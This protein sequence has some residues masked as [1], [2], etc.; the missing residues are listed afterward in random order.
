MASRGGPSA[1]RELDDPRVAKALA[2]PLRVR[3]LGVLERRSA[4]PR[5]LAEALDVGL[6]NLAYHVRKLRDYG[7]IELERRQKVGGAYEHVYRAKERP[8]ITASAWDALPDIAK[9][10]VIAATLDRLL[11]LIADAAE[12]GFERP[13]SL[14]ARRPYVLDP[15]AAGEAYRV[16]AEALDAIGALEQ[17]AA[18][19]IRDGDVEE[20]PVTAVALIFA[21]PDPPPA[22][23]EEDAGG[24]EG[25]HARDG[26]AQT[27]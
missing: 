17:E 21:T 14:I 23:L 13:D 19:R 12:T 4:T 20:L 9:Q 27:L 3:V 5:E 8:R 15:Q 18:E 10:A 24:P 7:L 16:M 11:P 6:E 2:H 25:T 26:G 22:A 1:I